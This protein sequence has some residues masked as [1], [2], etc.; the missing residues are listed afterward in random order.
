MSDTTA[1]IVTV[2]LLFSGGWVAG[3]FFHLASLVVRTSKAWIRHLVE[4]VVSGGVLVFIWWLNLWCS[5][6]QFRLG[7]VASIFLGMVAYYTICKEILD[8]I[9]VALYN[10]FTKFR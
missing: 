4:L 1:Q 2:A 9:Y 8:K 10:F 6:G 3:L 7:F 5:C